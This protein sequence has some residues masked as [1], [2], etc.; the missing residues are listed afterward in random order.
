MRIPHKHILI[1]TLCMLLIAACSPITPTLPVDGHDLPQQPTSTAANTA[2]PPT[3]TPQ[4]SPTPLPPL[5]PAPLY[6]LVGPDEGQQIWRV[7]MNGGLEHAV[8]ALPQGVTDFDVSPIDG[9]L[10]YVS[11]NQLFL[12]QPDGSSP[13][14][15]VS[16]EYPLEGYDTDMTLAIYRPVFS[17]DGSQ[18]A[19]GLNGLNILDL[20]SGQSRRLLENRVSNWQEAGFG[21]WVTY[22]PLFWSADGSKLVVQTGYYEGTGMVIVS[23][24]DGSITDPSFYNCCDAALDPNDSGFYVA[25]AMLAYGEPG[26]F[27]ITWDGMVE[28]ISSEPYDALY[29]APHVNA[30]GTL[31]FLYG[32]YD[33]LS[34]AS[35]RISEPG[36][37]QVG[38]T[39][40]Y[41]PYGALWSRDGSLLVLPPQDENRPV[42][43]FLPG[44]PLRSLNIS[45]SDFRWGVATLQDLQVAQTPIPEPT[46]TATLPPP[47]ASSAVITAENAAALQPIAALMSNDELYALA[48]SPDGSRLALGTHNSVRIWDLTSMTET[49]RFGPYENII[50]GLDFSRDG[51]KLAVGAW[52]QQLDVWDLTTGQRLTTF[53]GHSDSIEAVRFSPDGTQLASVSMDNTLRLWD[54]DSGGLLRII[55][56]DSW[57]EDVSYA[58]DGSTL[59]VA[60]WNQPTRIWDGS[61][62]NL[63]NS[64]TFGPDEWGLNLNYSP[65]GST[66]AIARWDYSISLWDT[67]SNVQRALC[68]GHGDNPRT[69]SFTPGGSL[70]A[71][72]DENGMVQIWDI[73]SG[74]QPLHLLTGTRNVAFSPDGRLLVT[75]GANIKGALI[76]AIP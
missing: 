17:P 70:M 1:L 42:Q 41:Q 23:S 3:N 24:A 14:L 49:A 19:Y 20:S 44:K 56:L 28:K 15:L 61:G 69:M 75:I 59:A 66:L 60:G 73:R 53:S 58:P 38:Q 50:T 62:A 72:A 27:L 6:M 67:A 26:L 57:G 74:C 13:L 34:V 30:E 25:S 18:I 37:I 47:S 29:S 16:G 32:S 11:A 12:S 31:Q 10:V 54:V 65:D 22:W 33:S 55:Q 8:T 40:D 5:L 35:M 52:D 46:P 36:N 39:L 71:S 9:R 43:L 4:P 64:I 51:Q 48:I 45:G 68:V 21:N 2:Q 76:Y 7:E 63:L